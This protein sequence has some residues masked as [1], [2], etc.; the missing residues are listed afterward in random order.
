MGERNTLLEGAWGTKSYAIISYD[1]FNIPRYGCPMFH[2]SPEV[3]QYELKS[4][5]NSGEAPQAGILIWETIIN[6]CGVKL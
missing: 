3:Q 5:G 6:Q 2:P 1:T 4:I